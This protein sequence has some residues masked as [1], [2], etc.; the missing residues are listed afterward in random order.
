[1]RSE[2]RRAPPGR[3]P[4]EPFRRRRFTALAAVAAVLVAVLLIVSA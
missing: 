3:R 1:M 2:L 4:T